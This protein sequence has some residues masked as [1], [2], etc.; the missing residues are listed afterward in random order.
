MHEAFLTDIPS[1]WYQRAASCI[2]QQK[3]WYPSDGENGYDRLMEIAE[4]FEIR[5]AAQA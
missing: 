3:A 5:A 1:R 4:R 2:Q